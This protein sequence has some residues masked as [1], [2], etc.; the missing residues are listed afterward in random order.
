MN[1]RWLAAAGMIQQLAAVVVPPTEGGDQIVFLGRDILANG[2][3]HRRTPLL[4]GRPVPDAAMA[5][6]PSRSAGGTADNV[7]LPFVHNI[8][9]HVGGP[10]SSAGPSPILRFLS[11]ARIRR[12]RRR[13]F[14][15]RALGR[16]RRRPA[17]GHDN[18]R[19]PQSAV[20]DLVTC[21]QHLHHSVGGYARNV[22]LDHGFVHMRIELLAERIETRNAVTLEN[23]EKLALGDLHAFQKR[24]QR[25]VLLDRFILRGFDGTAEIVADSD[26]VARK[27]RTRV[28][29]GIRF[30]AL[31]APPQ[32]LHLGHGAQKPVAKLSIF[33]LKRF[34]LLKLSLGGLAC[35][36]LLCRRIDLLRPA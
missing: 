5:L 9:V 14:C 13:T 25:R 18:C 7:G 27:F 26:R 23:L 6:C 35:L 29:L 34:K 36:W 24:L 28:F 10:A 1:G 30:L 21:V 8:D 16:P 17:L 2:P 12:R 11:G 22:H 32:I 31:R 15:L 4:G 19:G 3:R 20:C 33:G